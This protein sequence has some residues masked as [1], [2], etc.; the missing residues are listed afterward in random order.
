MVLASALELMTA[1]LTR[2]DR[3]EADPIY[4]R[5]HGTPAAR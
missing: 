1:L 5:E 4:T 2:W 3:A